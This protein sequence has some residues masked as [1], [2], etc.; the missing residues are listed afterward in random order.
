MTAVAVKGSSGFPG[1][2][3]LQ[4]QAAG[5][6]T[7]YMFHLALTADGTDA[8]GKTPAV[9][10]SKAGGAFA[11]A[12]GAVAEISG[13][14]YKCTFTA[15]DLNTLGVL[16]IHV[17]EASSDTINECAQV[18][19]YDP[20]DSVRLGLSSLPNAAFGA[21]GGLSTNVIRGGTAQ[22]GA[23][24][25][26]TLDA[27]ASATDHLYE[28][29]LVQITGG[30]GAGQERLITGYVGSTKVA[31]VDRN[32]ATNPDNTSVFELK[33]TNPVIV[34]QV[35][36]KDGSLTAAKAASDFLAASAG[37]LE[38]KPTVLVGT[39]TA[40][41]TSFARSMKRSYDTTVTLAGTFNGATVVIETTEDEN[42]ASPVWTDRSS[43]G[44][45]AGASLTI[46]GPHSAW[47]ARVSSGTVT[48]VTVKASDRVPQAVS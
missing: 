2:K 22:G 9:N 44:Y 5:A 14:W 17:T 25:T 46:T 1:Q 28:G 29:A 19:G 39:L 20:Y 47:R 18:V 48:S 34:D 31:T 23:A 30:T 42:A 26:I 45:T 36:L 10:I 27:G 38:T 8:T 21:S 12:A 16:A 11:A 6:K 43:G 37:K 4:S 7:V 15:T 3:F 33:A 40:S 32:W 24:G 13:G 35:V 41:A